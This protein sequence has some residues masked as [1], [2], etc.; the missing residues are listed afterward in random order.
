[1]SAAGV[2]VAALLVACGPA[3]TNKARVDALRTTRAETSAQAPAPET[4]ET[5]PWKVGQWVLY[6]NTFRDAAVSFDRISVVAED[7]CGTWIEWIYD[8]ENIHEAWLICFRWESN[9]TNNWDV[10]KQRIQIAVHQAFDQQP[11][12]LD[13]R[14]GYDD[15]GVTRMLRQQTRELFVHARQ[16]IRDGSRENVDVPAGHFVDA[17]RETSG[18]LGLWSHPEVP[19]GGMVKSQERGA[20][21]ALVAYGDSGAK[22]DLSD[23][24]SM[25]AFARARCV[26]PEPAYSPDCEQPVRQFAILGWGFGGWSRVGNVA[27]GRSGAVTIQAGQ[28]L[29]PRLH[30]VGEVSLSGPGGYS[31]DPAAWE[32]HT[33]LLLGIRWTPF[34]GKWVKALMGPPH[35]IRY[36]D[37]GG[38][39]VKASVGAGLRE[40]YAEAFEDVDWA[41]VLNAAIGLLPLKGR[42]WALGLEFREQLAFYS[43][44]LQRDWGLV[45]QAQVSR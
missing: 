5:K 29:W 41:P 44:G 37:K 34:R 4:L 19:L 15:V 7:R 24:A 18:D 2:M 27:P 1:M 8:D 45:L 10:T 36:S 40:R 3:A 13:F 16:T 42:D 12:L 11:R 9:P 22:S 31:P 33:A 39:Y 17:I 35:A 30:I 28:R 25:L 23:V 14:A 20:E 38:L 32:S 43:D 21:R 26:A 6:K